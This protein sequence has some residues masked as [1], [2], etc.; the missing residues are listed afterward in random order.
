MTNAQIKAMI[1]KESEE[2]Y[3]LKSL[4]TVVADSAQVQVYVI[5]K[6]FMS[7]LPDKILNQICE[8]VIC[9]KEVDRPYYEQDILFIIEQFQKWDHFK[10]NC[11]E[12]LFERK[13]L[14]KFMM[15]ASK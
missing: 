14:E 1:D 11:V 8:K 10:I 5:D 12:K 4:L 15:G 9:L 6:S 7:Y 13:R 3:Q 2:S